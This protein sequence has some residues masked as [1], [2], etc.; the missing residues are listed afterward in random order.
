MSSKMVGVIAQNIG[1]TQIFLDSGE[2][3]PVSVLQVGNCRVVQVKNAEGPDRYNAVQVGL[4]SRKTFKRITKPLRGHLK[5]AG[6]DAVDFLREFRVNEVADFEV[7]QKLDAS[8]FEAGDLIR[9]TGTSKG[10]GFA[11]VVKRHG[12]SGGP[13]SHGSHCGRI[14]G[15]I[16][17]SATPS[18]VHKGKKLP[19]RMGG[20]RVTLSRAK[21]VKVI[22][23]RNTIL[24]KGA[25][26]GGVGGR[27]LL[28]SKAGS[29]SGGKGQ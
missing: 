17:M 22:K 26:P 10:K 7:G 13:A 9:I 25:V 24:V 5:R 29:T 4:E 28:V 3:V 11:G 21:V 15:S 27:Y 14:P 12:F 8:L 23:E 20:E 1:M 19:G 6:L 16:G 2:V 18:R